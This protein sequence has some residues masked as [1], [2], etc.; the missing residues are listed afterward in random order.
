MTRTYGIAG[1]CRTK[2]TGGT[3][4]GE[5]DTTGAKDITEEIENEDQLLGAQAKDQPQDQPQVCGKSSPKERQGARC[6]L[7]GKTGGFEQPHCNQHW[8]SSGICFNM[9]PCCMECCCFERN[10]HVSLKASSPLKCR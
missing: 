3:G 6:I 8:E 4:L 1:L 9:D 10:S 7:H 5:G 2:Q